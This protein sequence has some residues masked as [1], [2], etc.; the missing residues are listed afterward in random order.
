M[1]PLA[2]AI[3]L[4]AAIAAPLL[5]TA[6]AEVPEMAVVGDPCYII[7]WT[8]NPPQPR[9]DPSCIESAPH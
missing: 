2:Y 8:A 9:V 6:A 7:D 4:F 3:V 1:K 5:G